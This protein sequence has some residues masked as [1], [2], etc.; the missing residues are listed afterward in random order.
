MCVR[1]YVLTKLNQGDPIVQCLVNSMVSQHLH[2]KEGTKQVNSYFYDTVHTS[3]SNSNHGVC[4]GDSAN[5]RF[6]V[7]RAMLS[8]GFKIIP[9]LFYF[10]KCLTYFIVY[11]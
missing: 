8:F 4:N 3:D 9:L 6:T 7:T 10:T 2:K 5:H 1:V 11:F